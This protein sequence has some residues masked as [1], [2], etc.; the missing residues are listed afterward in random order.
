MHTT[1]V[2]WVTL[3]ATAMRASAASRP[4]LVGGL[5]LQ[6][7]LHAH[8]PP[9]PLFSLALPAPVHVVTNSSLLEDCVSALHRYSKRYQAGITGTTV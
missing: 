5:A 1:T 8:P 9:P 7:S 2:A 6:A 4:L 3:D